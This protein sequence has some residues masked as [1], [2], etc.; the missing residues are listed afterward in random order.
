MKVKQMKRSKKK[1]NID[2]ILTQNM[3]GNH[4][5]LSIF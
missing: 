3:Q 2:Q 1:G 4:R 5:M